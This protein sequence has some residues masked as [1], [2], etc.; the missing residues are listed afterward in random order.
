[1]L[2]FLHQRKNSQKLIWIFVSTIVVIGMVAFY[3]PTRSTGIAGNIDEKT[4]V[5]K[6]SGDDITAGEYT[7]GLDMMMQAYQNMFSRGGGP[8]TYASLKA[9]GLDKTVLEGLIRKRIVTMEVARLGLEPTQDE[10]RA[11]IKEQ[12]SQDG[13]WIGFDK[14][15]K[16]IE[17]SGQT[18]TDY[19][20]SVK[21]LIAEEKLRSFVT[22]SIKVSPQELQE[23]FNKENTSFNVVYGI[24]DTE[25]F[26][27][28]V[29]TTDDELKAYFDSHKSEFKF[30]KQQRKVDYVF[31][32]QDNVA[33]NLQLSD[34]ELKKDFDPNKHLAGVRVSQ[35]LIK[36]LTPKDE[37][38][39]E[40][41]ANELAARARGTTGA[42]AEDFEALARGNSQDT[43]T[44]DKGGDL[45]LISKDATKAGSYLQ[46]AFSMQPGDISEPIRDG[47]NFYIL[48][49]TERKNKTFEEAKEALLASARNRLS[50]KKASE[51]ADEALKKLKETKDIKAVAAEVA[52]K[53]AMKTEEV[54]RQTPFFSEGDDVP[55]IGTNPSFEES[56]T[57]LKKVGEVG[58]KVGIR[59]GFALPQLV[60]VREPQDAAFEDVKSKV[61]KRYKQ[62]KAKDL[63]VQKAKELLASA[64][65]ADS[66][67][68]AIEKEDLKSYTKDDFK[69]GL[70]L[71]EFGFSK[72]LTAKLLAVKEGEV[73]KDPLENNGK[74]L[75]LGV[76]KRTD[77]DMTKYNDQSKLIEERLLE[78]RR[79]LTFNSYIESVKKKMKTDKQIV[80]YKEIIAQ[81]FGDEGKE[82]K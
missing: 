11:K 23:E 6:V 78:E 58:V 40:Q 35:I 31:V 10:M 13:K 63:T 76:T 38:L 14:Y 18:I 59:G 25:K 5:A 44:K 27:D 36:A 22:S 56:V 12:F 46:R 26:R 80:V 8:V 66:L 28:K 49:V 53:T 82:K 79:S 15:K 55:E 34:D 7:R 48:K 57:A 20:D 71:D 3:A 32:S 24:L 21:A 72:D 39:A 45:G 43:A 2:R 61:E 50:Y 41:K 37:E 19:E 68:A 70:S 67:K 75:V 69:E 30:E 62:E 81:I 17:R 51:V 65:K 42:K 4:L 52:Q 1:M 33:K 29:T 9:M 74:Y 77:P 54:L 60:S 47:S 64:A 73:I 16:L